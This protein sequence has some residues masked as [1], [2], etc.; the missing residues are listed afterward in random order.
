MSIAWDF[1]CILVKMYGEERKNPF[2][3]NRAIEPPLTLEANCSVFELVTIDD[4]SC[5]LFS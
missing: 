1:S 2:D 4:R 3:K 5:L